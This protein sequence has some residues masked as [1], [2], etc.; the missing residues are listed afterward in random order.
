MKSGQNWPS[1]H[2]IDHFWSKISVHGQFLKIKSG[3]KFLLIF[4]VF[5][6]EE[7]LQKSQNL[8]FLRLKCQDFL[9]KTN[10]HKAQTMSTPS[11]A[12]PVMP[13]KAKFQMTVQALMVPTIGIILSPQIPIFC[14]F[15]IMLSLF[16]GFVN[17]SFEPRIVRF[18]IINVLPDLQNDV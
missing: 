3:Q 13:I 15:K 9:P 10:L 6:K 1:G 11:H 16:S 2:K 12:P 7:A 8:P 14:L 18:C 17:T 5:E 4:V